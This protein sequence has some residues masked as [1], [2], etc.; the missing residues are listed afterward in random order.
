MTR[1]PGV[2]RTRPS[3]TPSGYDYTMAL[4]IKDP[5]TE[6]LAA[7]VAAMTGES[8]TGAIRQALRE[9]RDRLLLGQAGDR[10]Q[11]M[12]EALERDVWSRLPPGVRGVPIS[13]EEQDEILGYGPD[14]V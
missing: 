2:G 14:G 10:Y 8:K 13:Q 3:T 9:R 6:R 7:E 11:R 12:V 1:P 5:Q 4:N